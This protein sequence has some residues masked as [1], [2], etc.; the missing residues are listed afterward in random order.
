[1]GRN[2][3]LSRKLVWRRGR[4]GGGWEGNMGVAVTVG[5]RVGGVGGSDTGGRSIGEGTGTSGSLGG[6]GRVG[7]ECR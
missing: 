1:M 3:L 4:I 2:W 7:S 5:R 6:A